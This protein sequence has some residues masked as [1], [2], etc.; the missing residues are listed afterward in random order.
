MTTF[1]ENIYSHSK[2]FFAASAEFLYANEEVNSLLIGLLEA[3]PDSWIANIRANG[4]SA[5]VAGY[6]GVEPKNLILCGKHIGAVEH[7]D[8]LL[9]F[10]AIN[11]DG[12][13]GEPAVAA[14]AA[15]LIGAR[16]FRRPVERFRQLLYR[17][18]KVILPTDIA[19][20]SRLAEEGDFETLVNW[21]REFKR[22][23]LPHEGL[24]RAQLEKEA[25]DAIIKKDTYIWVVND[26]PV[27]CAQVRRPTARTMAVS[28][29]YTPK[30][31]RK[32][33]YASAITAQATQNILKSG[34]T[35]GVLYTDAANPTSNHIY[36]KL[37]YEYVADQS[38][39]GFEKL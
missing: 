36:E 19:G 1:T 29:V 34:K 16:T 21:R 38:Y 6:L 35:Y 23:A 4:D 2:D 28:Y 3:K 32:K 14:K 37:G 9:I 25:N 27:S 31:H 15:E 18:S 13:L 17:C 10:H 33:G 30:E 26:V 39:F 12:V 11:P 20:S 24:E 5:L 7:L 22:E 8:R